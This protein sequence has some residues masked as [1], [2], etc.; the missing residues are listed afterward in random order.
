MRS[1]PALVAL[2]LIPTAAWAI[3]NPLLAVPDEPAHVTKAVSIWYGQFT[4]ETPKP[5]TGLRTYRLPAKWDLRTPC[6]AFHWDQGPTSCGPLMSADGH[7]TEVSSYAGSYPPLYYALVGWP[8]RLFA[9]N[10]GIVLMRLV[11]ALLCSAFLAGAVKALQQAISAAWA[12]VGVLVAATPMT[13]FLSGSVNPNGFEI[14]TATALWAC[15]LALGRRA[16]V[17]GGGRARL[18]GVDRNLLI[19]AVVAGTACAFTRPLSGPFVGVVVVLAATS[20][21]WSTLRALA[22]SRAVVIGLVALAGLCLVAL[23]FSWATGLFSG[24]NGGT[25]IGGIPWPAATSHWSVVVGY[26]PVYLQEMLGLF[27]WLDTPISNLVLYGWL[28]LVFALAAGSLLLSRL[29]QNLAL[30]LTVVATLAIPV[31]LQ[32]PLNGSGSLVWQGRY[33]LPIAVGIPLLAVLGIGRGVHRLDGGGRSLAVGVAAGA[34]LLD[35][36]ALYWNLHRYTVGFTSHAIDLS[37]GAWQP[38]GGW[39][40]WVALMVVAAAVAVT[41]VAVGAD[42]P[43]AEP[44]RETTGDLTGDL[45]AGRPSYVAEGAG[46]RGRPAP[47]RGAPRGAHRHRLG[48]RRRTRPGPARRRRRRPSRPGGGRAT[49]RSPRPRPPP[50]PRGATRAWTG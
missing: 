18:D 35:A 20:V 13:L 22:R 23:A 36:Y 39:R 15:L 1:W 3:S 48:A 32:A 46:P 28:G 40:V 29:R 6:Y 10:A 42:D 47:E 11:S 38:H 43:A 21:G 12:L 44:A 27:G 8:G 37:R 50:D 2:F 34:G 49:R 14:C 25:V 33:I 5:G 17:A 19:G 45:S 7:V 9:S 4:G 31:V 26:T 16:E 24:V 41:M 30:A